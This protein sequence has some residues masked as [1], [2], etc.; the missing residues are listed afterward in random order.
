M[1]GRI[2]NFYSEGNRPIAQRAVPRKRR[3]YSRRQF[4]GDLE[5]HRPPEP[6]WSSCLREATTPWQQAAVKHNTASRKEKRTKQSAILQQ[7]RTFDSAL[8][9]IICTFAAKL[10]LSENKQIY[11]LSSVSNFNEVKIYQY[12]I[13]E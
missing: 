7:K 13:V 9:K 2:L 5:V 11:L 12:G 8:L 3:M 6:L 10:R 4:C 1:N